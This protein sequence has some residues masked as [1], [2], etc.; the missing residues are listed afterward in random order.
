M[1]DWKSHLHSGWSALKR[2]TGRGLAVLA[3]GGLVV[4]TAT[5]DDVVFSNKARFRIPYQLDS[6]EI[7]RL[8]AA[9]IQLHV[10]TDGGT[11]WRLV[12]SVPPVEGKFTFEAAQDGEYWF[13]VRTLGEN[14]RHHPAGPLAA[15]L[16]VFVDTVPPTLDLQ[17]AEAAAG[18]VQLRWSA[19]DDHLNAD[20]LVLEYRNDGGN[21]ERVHVIPSAAGETM[22]SVPSG[23][24]IAVRGKVQ[25]RADN[26]V[27]QQVEAGIAGTAPPQAP[28]A[29]AVRRPIA[30][31]QPVVEPPALAA[32]LAQQPAVQGPPSQRPLTST[33]LPVINPGGSNYSQFVSQ[34]GSPRPPVQEMPW[35]TAEQQPIA[36]Q[37]PAASPQMAS[38][39]PQQHPSTPIRRV[40]S[41]NFQIGY[42][43][44]DVGPSGVSS[45]DLFL[46]E[47][48]GQ[49]WF[50]FGADAD[51]VS[52]FE[53][54]V[55]QDG[56]YGFAIRVRSGVGLALSPPQPGNLPEV[57]VAVDREPPQVKL[58]PLKQGQ[59][60]QPSQLLIEWTMSD[61]E[62]ADRPVSLYYASRPS[63]PWQPITG[64]EPNT[65]QYLWAFGPDAPKQVYIRLDA[66]DTAGNIARVESQEPL[67]ID[68]S[69]PT[70][71]IIDVES[72]SVRH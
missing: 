69:R 31:G 68:L 4:T 12:D 32:P 6:A 57:V 23:G 20:S 14:G 17:V 19:A 5:A 60:Q 39:P 66:R 72:I 42:A 34:E 45:V 67:L 8:K 43:L 65:G 35:E 55:P 50:H 1:T 30:D 26:Q 7:Q 37:Q 49:K 58:M 51:G 10:S 52:P 47:D 36:A 21:W 15:G 27:I 28:A 29:P 46:T 24:T 48:N 59:G 3:L 54:T 61:A 63:G 13:S 25:D 56:T 11:Q 70:A 38:P 9:E 22:W 71:R 33:G 2:G 62:L 16:K 41:T 40:N 18:Q 44:D 53:V 64:W